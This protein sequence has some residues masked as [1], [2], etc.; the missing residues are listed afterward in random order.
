M[1]S[2]AKEKFADRVAE[3]LTEFDEAQKKYVKSAILEEM[4]YHVVYTPEEVAEIIAEPLK[5]L[6]K[7]LHVKSFE[8]FSKGTIKLYK[9]NV[10]HFISSIIKPIGEITADDIRDYLNQKVVN[11]TSLSYANNIRSSLSSFFWWIFNENFIPRNPMLKVSRIK[12]Q[13]EQQPAFNEIEI[14]RIRKAAAN[15]PRDIALV[16]FL[17]STGCRVS[18]VRN[19]DIL[20]VNFDKRKLNVIGKGNKS[21]IVYLTDVAASS[22]KSYLMNRKDDECALFVSNISPHKRLSVKGI[23]VILSSIGKNAHVENVHPHRFRHTCCTRLLC[24]GMP[25]QDVARILGHD[26]VNTTMLYNNTTNDY[27]DGKFRQYSF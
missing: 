13:H 27:I 7:F 4:Q 14:D 22:L 26:N 25:I 8:G 20:D 11:G 17:L 23:Q 18:E 5:M 1:N 19:A 9:F 24:R 15:D 10:T 3:R 16:D 2:I 6:E 21:R 12:Y